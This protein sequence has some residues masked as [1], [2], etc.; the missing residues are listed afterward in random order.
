M[1][2]SS[3]DPGESVHLRRL[4]ARAFVAQQYDTKYKFSRDVQ[5]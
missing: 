5:I 4:A 2:A 1:H 3:E